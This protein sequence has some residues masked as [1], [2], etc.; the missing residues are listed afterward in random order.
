M[1]CDVKT[2]KI[3]LLGKVIQQDKIREVSY[4]KFRKKVGR[5][6]IEDL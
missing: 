6:K 4:E 5:V 1:T 3:T 2:G